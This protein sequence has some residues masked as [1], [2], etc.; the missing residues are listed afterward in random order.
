[1]GRRFNNGHR[2]SLI[3]YGRKGQFRS[4]FNQ[5]YYSRVHINLSLDHLLRAQENGI[6]EMAQNQRLRPTRISSQFIC[7]LQFNCN[8]S[9][10]YCHWDFD[11]WLAA[12]HSLTFT[13]APPKVDQCTSTSIRHLQHIQYNCDRKS[14]TTAANRIVFR[15]NWRH[16]PCYSQSY[17]KSVWRRV[18]DCRASHCATAWRGNRMPEGR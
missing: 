16:N 2:V 14:W 8:W 4:I 3:L 17:T 5:Y 1:M 15:D 18:S 13:R 7:A 9:Q 12:S 6:Q 11:Y 10:L